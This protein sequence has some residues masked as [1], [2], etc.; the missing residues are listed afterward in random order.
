MR[1]SPP[2]SAP[3]ATG[4]RLAPRS[5]K[6]EA[7]RSSS[8]GQAAASDEPATAAMSTRV[9]STTA[10]PSRA[11][12]A[13]SSAGDERSM[14]AARIDRGACPGRARS[15][16]RAP[17]PGRGRGTRSRSRASAT[18]LA[19]TRPA[20]TS[21]AVRSRITSPISSRCGTSSGRSPGRRAISRK[22]RTE[23]S[24]AR[25][26]VEAGRQPQQREVE[27]RVDVEP[28]PRRRAEVAP[29]EARIV[30]RVAAR[31]LSRLARPRGVERPLEVAGDDERVGA[32][33]V[34]G[35]D[36][37]GDRREQRR[38]A[39]RRRASARAPRRRRS[40]SRRPVRR[41]R[42]RAPGGVDEP[43]SPVER[44][45][46][47]RRLERQGSDRRAE[48]AEPMRQLGG[49]QPLALGRDRGV[50]AER[51]PVGRRRDEDERRGSLRHRPLRRIGLEQ[52][53][54]LLEVHAGRGRRRRGATRRSAGGRSAD[55]PSRSAVARA[56]R[57]APPPRGCARR[58]LSR[59]I[60]SSL[61]RRVR[62]ARGPTA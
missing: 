8:G 52:P 29:G 42:E 61:A 27:R 10:S 51:L 23:P 9:S 49:Q 57:C 5:P 56:R 1:R 48:P 58:D 19:G 55:A 37:A 7:K 53:V 2:R 44:L 36:L 50:G 43:A 46:V 45:A 30:Q 22:P 20:T 15:A 39:R 21:S 14:S 59:R 17:R 32:E 62:P 31:A 24:S 16:C 11:S 28:R 12:S 25:V 38:R 40:R 33:A 54:E 41:P 18:S 34:V 4:S 6:S 13:T 3:A 47:G 35:D 60:R 26:P